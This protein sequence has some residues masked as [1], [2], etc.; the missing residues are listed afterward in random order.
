MTALAP[1]R[2][3]ENPMKRMC[4]IAGL[5]SLLAAMSVAH[6]QMPVTANPDHEQMLA[7]T[8]PKL[9]KNKRLVYDF[10]REVFESGHL[11]LAGKYMAESYIQHNPNV[12]TGRAA[13]VEFFSK[14]A[15][16]APIETKVKAPLVA[17]TAEG[18]LVVLSFVRT[19]SDPK[20]PAKNYT[21]TWFDMFRI[22]NGKIAEH[23]DAVPKQ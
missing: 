15:K 14:F 1:L 9:A 20:D 5:V 17:I 12:P 11:E 6:A 22:E 18:D 21:T 16:P 10:W 13:F 23:W 2:P 7:S 4:A 8:D 19:S 3:E